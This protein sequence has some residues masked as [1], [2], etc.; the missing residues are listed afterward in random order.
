MGSHYESPFRK[1][2][3]TG[4]KSYGD[5]TVDIARA[6][7]TPPNWQ[8]FLAFGIALLAFLLMPKADSLAD[9]LIIL[10]FLFKKDLPG[11]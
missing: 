9:N 3:V 2:L 11:L 10:F 8:W 1:P 4:N 5:V 6:V 7:E